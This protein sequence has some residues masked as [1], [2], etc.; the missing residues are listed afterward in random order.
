MQRTLIH[1]AT[2]TY[3][4]RALGLDIQRLDDVLTSVEWALS[5]NPDVYEVVKGTQSTRLLKTDALGGLPP[6]RVWFRISEDG[7][8]VH[9]E[10]IEAV[11]QSG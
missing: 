10:Y 2:Y 4:L 11:E 5:T 9:L 1:E 6:L 7:Q 8:H 3:A